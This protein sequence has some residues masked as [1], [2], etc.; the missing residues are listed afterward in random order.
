ME[1]QITVELD[2]DARDAL[3]ALEAAGM[4]RAE[5]ISKALVNAAAHLVHRAPSVEPAPDPDS[6]RDGT[7]A[8]AKLMETLHASR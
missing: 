4:S 8:A 5:A 7:L 1:R 3:V 6:E 2:E